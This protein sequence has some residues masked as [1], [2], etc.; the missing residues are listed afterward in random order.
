MNFFDMDGFIFDT[1]KLFIKAW[2]YVG[3]NIQRIFLLAN[4]K[5]EVPITINGIEEEGYFRGI[6]YWG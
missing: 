4:F 3:D 5:R 2:D 1:E 6:G